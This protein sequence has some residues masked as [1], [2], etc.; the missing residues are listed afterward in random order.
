MIN[1]SYFL[2]NWRTYVRRCLWPLPRLW[3]EREV[4]VMVDGKRPHG[5]LTD[6]FRNILS[7]YSYCKANG[8]RFRVYYFFPT[9]LTEYLVPNEYDWRISHREIS[10][11]RLDSR[12][13]KLYVR[14]LPELEKFRAY[15][16]LGQNLSDERLQLARAHNREYNNNLHLT[17]LDREFSKKRHC[18][19]HIYRNAFFARGKFRPLFEE[20]FRPSAYLESKLKAFRDGHL[21]PYESVT[22]RFQMLLGD[23]EEGSF[24]VLASQQQDELMDKCSNKIDELW[25]NKYFSTSKV[26][27]TSD[28][29]RFL[30]YISCKEYV[31]TVPGRM[32]HMDITRNTDIEVNAKSFLDLFLLMQSKKLTLLITGKMYRSGFPAFAAELGGKPYA[33]I[34]F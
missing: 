22:L 3:R 21:E 32:V 23:F 8:I 17:V 28:S 20:L 19:Y 11:H 7:L 30:S 5:G 18:Q 4:V 15:P 26:L 25:R 6:R 33:E 16:G 27:V 9:P 29:S 12:D 13:I 24:E 2:S 10:Y 34:V 1:I 14:V 31:Y